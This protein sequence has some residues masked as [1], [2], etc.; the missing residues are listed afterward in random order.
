MRPRAVAFEYECLNEEYQRLALE[1]PADPQRPVED[2]PTPE[3]GNGE[4]IETPTVVN[5]ED[6]I[7]PDGD[8]PE[9]TDSIAEDQWQPLLTPA[10]E[11]ELRL[12][13]CE[14]RSELVKTMDLEEDNL[15]EIVSDAKA[16]AGTG[17][18]K[19]KVTER[20][21]PFPPPDGFHDQRLRRYPVSD[22]YISQFSYGHT[23][24][25]LVQEEG[26]MHQ[27]YEFWFGKGFVWTDYDFDRP[28]AL[29]REQLGEIR[30]I[31]WEITGQWDTVLQEDAL[32]VIYHRKPFLVSYHT[33][34]RAYDCPR[35]PT[36][37]ECVYPSERRDDRWIRNWPKSKSGL[38]PLNGGT[39]EDITN[40]CLI[41]LMC[42]E[43]TCHATTDHSPDD[44]QRL[45][46]CEEM[47]TAEGTLKATGTAE[48]SPF[49]KA[50]CDWK[51]EGGGLPGIV[52]HMAEVN[53]RAGKPATVSIGEPVVLQPRSTRIIRLKVDRLEN[54]LYHVVCK[55]DYWGRGLRCHDEIVNTSQETIPVV[56]T[57]RSYEPLM[58]A[59]G[60]KPCYLRMLD[61][62]DVFRIKAKPRGIP[63]RAPLL[64]LN[65]I[66]SIE[67]TLAC[68]VD[69]QEFPETCALGRPEGDIS[70]SQT[71]ETFEN[72]RKYALDYDEEYFGKF[73]TGLISMTTRRQSWRS[74]S[75]NIAIALSSKAIRS[76]KL[77]SGVT[78]STLESHR[79]YISPR[80]VPHIM[81]KKRLRSL[82]SRCLT[83]AISPRVVRLGVRR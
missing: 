38:K 7:T 67:G 64:S 6:D 71:S 77:R 27:V 28:N 37:S 4:A 21:R 70:I 83:T 13:G 49:M 80:I 63:P 52:E 17:E 56:L 34:V 76:V 26:H 31:L 2:L 41:E 50:L 40:E 11:E 20:P 16:T 81:K 69:T 10:T 29:L 23:D 14:E 25:T 57:N 46:T 36:K 66:S 30:Q 55:S 8:D 32:F 19:P 68:D 48:L 58:L 47:A 75:K 82:F 74:F 24:N 54:R 18:A 45:K 53:K 78:S 42:G 3:E 65:G 5:E 51:A 35:L 61:D 44:S 15:I 62:V 60:S 43:E 73:K 59:S 72:K 39:R 22:S 9:A 12:T 1:A 79:P 33:P